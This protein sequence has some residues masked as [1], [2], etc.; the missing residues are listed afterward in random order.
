MG[1]IFGGEAKPCQA[2]A[3]PRIVLAPWHL[4]LELQNT[5]AC[6]KSPNLHSRIDELAAQLGYLSWASDAATVSV[7]M[8]GMV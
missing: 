7:T 2:L 8:A 3:L 4:R 6:L 1:E 5:R